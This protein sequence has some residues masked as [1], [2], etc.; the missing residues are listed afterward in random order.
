ALVATVALTVGLLW[1]WR[2]SSTPTRPEVDYST[3]YGWIAADKVTKVTFRNGAIDGELTAP[4]PDGDRTV[5]TFRT[6]LPGADDSLLPL[7]RDHHVQIVA[8][9]PAQTTL[10][11]ILL[12]LLPW[13][14]LIGAWL[15]LSRRSRAAMSPTAGLGG[16]LRRGKRFE[17]A[18][19][20]HVT[21]DDVAG[22][23]A[24]KRD[25]REIVQFLVAPD[26]FRALG[27]KVPR[28]VLLIGPPGTGKTLIARAVAGEAKV[29]FYSI[30]GSEFIEMFVGVGAARVRDLFEEAKRNAPSIVFIDEID[31]VGRARGAGLGGGHDER[32]QTLNQLLSEMDGFERNDLT[33]VIAAT[34]RPDV[35]DQALLR[36]GRFDR[37]VVVALPELAA[38]E[39]ILRVHTAN[40]PLADDVDLHALAAGTPGFSGADLANLANEAALA[41]ARRDATT[42]TAADFAEAFDKIV[43]GDPREGRLGD[44]ERRRV[45]IHEA[46]HA[47]VAH[48]S[49]HAEPVR[50][51]SIL[52]RGMALGVTQQTPAEDRHL[53]T[54]SELEARLRVALGGRA[55]EQLVLGE[56]SSGAEDDLRQATRLAAKMVA[57]YGMSEALGAVY[58]PIEEEHPFLGRRIATD[59]GVS[60][61][62]VHAIELAS[63]ALLG[64]AEASAVA[65]LA[66]HRAE[67]DALIAALLA[68]ETVE[69]DALDGVLAAAAAPTPSITPRSASRP[70]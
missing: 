9:A 10:G 17:H 40:K 2:S 5:T 51:V 45:A 16:F 31:A 29:P 62:T 55:A 4:Q 59:A 1:L 68:H 56:V 27:G 18:A 26:R 25:L 54:R 13:V 28:G 60:D 39:E 53:M 47:L 14:V 48:L 66:A 37:R 61:A 24:A 7:L 64:D 22:L 23:G 12:G 6:I 70:A 20:V 42:I 21:F 46:G 69:R 57:H 34:N 3:A 65:T 41:A 67:L 11:T 50:R 30:S 33:I 15:W 58:Y 63:R 38:R 19:T 8:I 44:V 52:P 36:P 49:P 35:L 43:L 32:E